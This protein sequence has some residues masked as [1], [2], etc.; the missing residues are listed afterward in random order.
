VE[1]MKRPQAHAD[2]ARKLIC[3]ALDDFALLITARIDGEVVGTVRV[4]YSR[5][6][7]LGLYERLY[8]MAQFGD[9][10]PA[11]TSITTKLMVDQ[12]LRGSAVAK[13]MCRVVYLRGL[14][15]GIRLNLIDCNDNLLSLYQHLGYRKIRDVVHPE[16]GPVSLLMLDMNDLEY[17]QAVH[18]P[19]AADLITFRLAKATT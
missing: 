12:R 14:A 5:N 6:G 16:Y 15:D 18:S 10:H 9:L 2:H 3:E 13:Q 1:E 8:G 17:L 7:D 4:N 11:Y 19:F